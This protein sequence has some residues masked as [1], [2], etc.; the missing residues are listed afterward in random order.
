MKNQKSDLDNEYFYINDLYLLKFYK[1][2]NLNKEAK[3]LIKLL[4]ESLLKDTKFVKSVM[5]YTVS[6]KVKSISTYLIFKPIRDNNHESEFKEY[7][8]SIKKRL[9][10]LYNR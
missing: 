6:M 10:P 9:K 2:Y 5:N 3:A 4:I 8:F 7:I 1:K